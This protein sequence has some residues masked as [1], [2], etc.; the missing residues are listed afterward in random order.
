MKFTLFSRVIKIGKRLTLASACVHTIA[1]VS[2]IMMT[3]KRNKMGI[4]IKKG[5]S[6]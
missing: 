6:S 5:T 2:K 4:T 3:Q 1:I